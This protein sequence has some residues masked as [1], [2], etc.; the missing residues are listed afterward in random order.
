M[1]YL[2]GGRIS[3]SKARIG[4]PLCC[5]DKSFQTHNQFTSKIE[6]TIQYYSLLQSWEL[7]GT[8]M[9]SIR[10]KIYPCPILGFNFNK[11]Q[12]IVTQH[13]SSSDWFMIEMQLW[14]F[15]CILR[16]FSFHL[17]DNLSSS[18]SIVTDISGARSVLCQNY[19]FW[20]F[21]NDL[22]QGIILSYNRPGVAAR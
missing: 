3:C 8:Q 19:T 9:N 12:K 11:W 7:L 18:V 14:S 10:R 2:F 5:F 17:I 6:H 20:Y 4:F 13:N 22:L 16:L 21:V 1:K 15:D